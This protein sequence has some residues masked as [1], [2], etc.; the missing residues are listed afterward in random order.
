[1]V[2]LL[3]ID[4]LY[5]DGQSSSVATVKFA[6]PEVQQK[7]YLGYT[8]PHISLFKESHTTWKDLGLMAQMGQRATDWE[9]V[10]Q[11][12]WLSRSTG[13]MR[14]ALYWHA[15]VKAEVHLQSQIAK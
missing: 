11:K 8:T 12:K 14:T 13:L 5:T 4:H 9:R 1:M 10:D 2:N 6:E 3:T 15:P 7:F